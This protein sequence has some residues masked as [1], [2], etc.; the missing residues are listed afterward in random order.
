[1]NELTRLRQ[2]MQQKSNV[3]QSSVNGATRLELNRRNSLRF[4]GFRGGWAIPEEP[5][6]AI[7]TITGEPFI[8]FINIVPIVTIFLIINVECR[9]GS[10]DSRSSTMEEWS[11]LFTISRRRGLAK[12][13]YAHKKIRLS[14]AVTAE[15]ARR[16]SW[17]ST[18]GTL[19]RILQK[20]CFL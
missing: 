20:S 3:L 17:R 7:D 8:W 12:Y 16:R 18:Q 1:M 13:V 10:K 4:W 19:K 15:T 6:A 5:A 2:I 9:L 11:L 14:R